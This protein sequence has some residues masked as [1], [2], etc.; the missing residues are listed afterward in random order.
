MLGAIDRLEPLGSTAIYGALIDA[1]DTIDVGGDAIPSIVLMTDGEVTDGPGLGEFIASVTTPVWQDG[2]DW[3][4]TGGEV[5]GI[6]ARLQQLATT[7]AGEPVREI[8]VGNRGGIGDIATWPRAGV[9]NGFEAGVVSSAWVLER[10]DGRVF[11]VTAGF[12]DQRRVVSADAPGAEHAPGRHHAILDERLGGAGGHLLRLLGSVLLVQPVGGAFRRAAGVGKDEGGPPAAHLLEDV[13]DH[14]RPHR[15]A[16]Q[17]A[18]ILRHGDDAQVEV[19]VQPGVDDGDGARLEPIADPLLADEEA[20]HLVERPLGGREADALHRPTHQ[21]LQPLQDA[22]GLGQQRG[23]VLGRLVA[24]LHQDARLEAPLQLGQPGLRG[25][26]LGERLG[27]LHR[28][29]SAWRRVSSAQ[30]TAPRSSNWSMTARSKGSPSAVPCTSMSFPSPVMTMFMS[31][32]AAESSSYGR[33]ST[34]SPSTTPTLI[35]ATEP[36]SG[37]P[38]RAPRSRR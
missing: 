6:H 12:N 30:P 25:R 32:S 14:R 10:N 21:V 34:A 11:F 37:S 23:R 17:G 9:K 1:Y 36:L 16:G 24:L 33:S 31:T 4:L 13:G 5:C 26:P 18:E 28:R 35:A 8:L 2:V 38:L 7:E 27:E 20:G 3:S 29:A 15:A 19:L 22:V